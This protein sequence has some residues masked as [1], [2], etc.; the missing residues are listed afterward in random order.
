MKVFCTAKGCKYNT[1]HNINGH[2][3]SKCKIY[4]HG[5]HECCDNN[6]INSLSLIEISDNLKCTI[7]ECNHSDNHTNYG[8]QCRK[9]HNF[10]HGWKDCISCNL[11]KRINHTSTECI[12]SCP[13]LISDNSPGKIYV[14]LYEGMGCFSFHKRSHPSHPFEVFHMHSDEYGQYGYDKTPLLERFLKGY[15]PLR[16]IDSIYD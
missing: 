16:P 8:H 15:Q 11:C 1:Y 14:R 5:F 6:L 9:C 7:S 2:R 4:G 12:Y 3:C 10:G 13:N